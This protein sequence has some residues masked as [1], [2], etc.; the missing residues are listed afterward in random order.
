MKRFMI[1]SRRLM[2]IFGP[3]VESFVL[4]MFDVKAHL[5]PRSAVRTQLIRDHHAR[6]RAGGF[7]ELLH[8]KL[9]SARVSSALDQDVENEAIL[10]DS[11]PEPMLF[12]RDRDNDLVQMPFVTAGGSALAD[13]IGERLAEFPSPLAHGFIGHANAT[14]R[15]H[16]L[17][18][19]QA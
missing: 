1:R 19:A 17:D 7:Q 15:Q 4:A 8:E 18:H 14:R 11:A 5:R 6:R 12:A 3:I 13:P 16:F 2:R 9:R 10:V